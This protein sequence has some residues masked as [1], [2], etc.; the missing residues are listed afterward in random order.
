LPVRIAVVQQAGNP[1]QVDENRDKALGFARQALAAG[2]EFI[3]FHEGLLVGYVENLGELAEPVDGPTTQVF[4]SLLR[5]TDAL[6][7]YGLIERDGS[8]LY[9]AATLVSQS[10]VQAKYRKTH[11][12]WKATGLRHEPS[13]FL[14]GNELVTFPVKGFKSGVM[15][16]YDGDFPEMTRAYAN[17]GCTMLF[18][19]NNRRSRGHCEVKHLARQN[20]MT[21]ATACCCGTNEA[22][23]E[24][25][26]GSNIVDAEGQLLAEIWNQEGII[27]ADVDPGSVLEARQRNPWYTGQRHDLYKAY[28]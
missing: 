14:P 3:L 20:S 23:D 18:W 21:M 10:G 22:G 2:A 11:L 1:G 26:G 8:G 28:M 25:P 12:W 7:L 19:M 13:Y 27:Y 4:Q 16:C 5:G 24:C 15:I 6:I 17:L 9:I